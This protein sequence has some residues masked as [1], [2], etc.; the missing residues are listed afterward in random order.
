VSTIE[1][2]TDWTRPGALAGLRALEHKNAATREV[3]ARG[4][5]HLVEGRLALARRRAHGE[6]E[7][8]G[9][10]MET[11]LD[12]AAAELDAAAAQLQQA[13]AA[14]DLAWRHVR[15]WLNRVAPGAEAA[16]S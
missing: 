7:A 6:P 16:E 10:P 4:R 8:V 13:E 9:R 3:L 11:A 2:P 1:A 15:D 12:R 5:R 14:A